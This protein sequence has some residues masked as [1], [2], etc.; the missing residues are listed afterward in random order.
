MRNRKSWIALAV[1]LVLPLPFIAHSQTLTDPQLQAR[2]LVSGLVMP[3]TMAFIGTNDILVLEKDAGK[4]RRVLDGALLSDAVL[5]LAVDNLEERGL[6]GI[7]VHPQ[8]PATNWVYLYYSAAGSPPTNRIARFEWNGSAVT[9]ESVLL[10]LPASFDGHNGGVLGFGPDGKLYAVIGDQGLSGLFQNSD[11]NTPAEITSAIVRINDD[12]S[13]PADNPF[14]ALGG[15]FTRFFAYGVRNSFGFG[16]DP[17]S[18]KLWDTENGFHDYNEINLVE[19]GFNSGWRKIMGPVSRSASTTNDLVMIDGAHYADP[20]FSWLATVA[21]TAIT[22]LSSTNLGAQYEND[23]FVGDF[24]TGTLYRFQPNAQRDGFVFTDPDLAD[25]IADD[26]GQLDEVIFGTGFGAISDVEVGPDGNLY[27][28]SISGGTI[29]VIEP[30][31]ATVDLAAVWNADGPKQTCKG[32]GP[33][34][35]CKLKGRL[36]VHATGSTGYPASS[37][38]F[39]LSD[40]ATFDVGDAPLGDEV[41][42]AGIKTGK[43]KKVKLKAIMGGAS[44]SGKYIIAILDPNSSVYETDETNNAVVYGPLL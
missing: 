35:Q 38:R 29:V 14:F 40:D 37:V 25:L 7:A 15:V 26:N 3:T 9:N 8:F 10:E 24:N 16:F 19:P 18:G 28:L 39:Y 22:F 13:V 43:T 33:S 42:L 27:V 1:W 31:A 6:L 5:Q 2:Q 17:V 21:P 20:K 32:T 12:G 30:K 34:L 41:A 11:T 36:L 4:V 44:V 23:A